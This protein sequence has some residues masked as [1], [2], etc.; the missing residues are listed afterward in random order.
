MHSRRIFDICFG[1]LLF[2]WI[3]AT[4]N[5]FLTKIAQ[6]RITKVGNSTCVVK[7]GGCP[8][9][10]GCT[11]V[12]AAPF[13]LCSVKAGSSCSANTLLCAGPTAPGVVPCSC[14]SFTC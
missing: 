4:G 5:L 13:S 14:S 8:A 7:A 11:C 6:A 2:A 9:V 3:V 10:V 12:A 1:F